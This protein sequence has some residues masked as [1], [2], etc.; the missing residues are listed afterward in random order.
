MNTLKTVLPNGKEVTFS[1]P[2]NSFFSPSG[3]VY[4]LFLNKSIRLLLKHYYPKLTMYDR[5]NLVFPSGESTIAF[6]VPVSFGFPTNFDICIPNSD[7]E[8]ITYCMKRKSYEKISH[9]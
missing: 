8:K 1:Y 4:T 6:V 7:R 2:N 9:Y 5:I 3:P